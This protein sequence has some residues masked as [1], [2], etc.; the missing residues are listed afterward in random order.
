MKSGTKKLTAL[1]VTLMVCAL[2]L[3]AFAAQTVQADQSVD[4]KKQ[5]YLTDDQY[6]ALGFSGLK[7]PAAFSSTD[8]SDPLSGYSASVLSELLVGQVNRD[9]NEDNYEG[10]FQIMQGPATA[11]SSAMNLNNMAKSLVGGIQNYFDKRNDDGMYTQC[12]NTIALRPGKISETDVS[13]KDIIIEDTLYC[14]EGGAFQQDDSMQRIMAWSLDGSD[15]YH[16]GNWY[17]KKLDDGHWVGDIKVKEADG[18]TAMAVGDFD[19]DDYYEVAV[20]TP[21]NGGGRIIFFQLVQNGDSCNLQEESYSVNIASLSD[22]YNMDDGIKRPTV[23]LNTTSMA[24]RDDLA[25]SVSLPYSGQD[26]CCNNSCL[27]IYSFQNGSASQCFNNNLV[28]NNDAYRF[29][30]NAT[31][32]ADLNGDGVD[33]LVVAGNK[34]DSYKT[35]TPKERSAPMRIW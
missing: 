9:D 33:E 19:G 7:D 1:I 34:N 5:N 13:T 11:D 2:G 23:Q 35:A 17:T 26:N 6:A 22:Y 32:N 30:F 27:A 4:T 15:A 14:Q 21:E 12:K 29:K 10:S 20:F 24:G 16:S 8:T 18:F 25:I 31:C 3:P 28:V